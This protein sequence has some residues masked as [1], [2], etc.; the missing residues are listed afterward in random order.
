MEFILIIIGIVIVNWMY[1]GVKSFLFGNEKK[2]SITYND[3]Q[4]EKIEA[5]ARHG[6][7]Q[8]RQSQKYLELEKPDIEIVG[9][10][11]EVLDR[12]E[13]SKDNIFLT[14]K[15][16][17]GKSTLLRYFR[18][19]T[20]KNVVVVAPTGVAAINVQGQ[21]IHSFFKFGIAITED[22][23]KKIYGQKGEIYKKIDTLVIDEIS[24]VR[25]DIFDCIDKFL[26]LNGPNPNLPFGGI[27]IVV[28]GDLYQLPPVVK[29]EE[30][31]IFEQHYKSPFFFDAKSYERANFKF[32]ELQ[33]V[34]RQ[35]DEEFIKI[36]DQIRIGAVADENLEII[37]KQLSSDGFRPGNFNVALVPINAM[38]EQINTAALSEIDSKESVYTGHIIGEFKENELPTSLEL[39]LKE[40]A[41][42][43]LLNNDPNNKWVNGDLAKILKLNSAS[44]RVIFEDNTFEDVAAY[45]WDKVRFVF[46]ENRKKIVSE[47]TGSFTQLPIK[48]AW[49]IT[50]HKSQGK[51]YNKVVIDF[52][53]G[54]FAAGQA[55]V[56]LSRC[57]SL[58]GLSLSTKVEK[59]HIFVDERVKEFINNI[60][61]K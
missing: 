21:T 6:I 38:A 52:G 57:R 58:E 16:G 55:Y 40:G 20:D 29:S 37:N 45:K 17:T 19:T 35:K 61:T 1:K 41:Q 25:A 27:Q 24:M 11:K 18:A 2:A 33:N 7:G 23:V 5:L 26:R 32:I 47:I 56:A 44:V 42:I 22:K 15:A 4:N 34:R 43:M 31:Y 60:Y 28:I 59:D 49:A 53:S 46:D 39:V 12:L 14:G 3:K 36:L 48:L 54:T 51:S 8:R 30:K 9:E 50:I 13:N 10:T